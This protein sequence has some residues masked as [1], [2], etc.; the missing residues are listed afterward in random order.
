M[1][2]LERKVEIGGFVARNDLVIG[3]L[4][5]SDLV[6]RDLVRADLVRGRLLHDRVGGLGVDGIRNLERS[7]RRWRNR[8]RLG[9]D[10]VRLR[11]DLRFIFR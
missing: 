4:V 9:G 6:C 8:R 1:I 10:R 5:R 3:D 7:D 11:F 2:V